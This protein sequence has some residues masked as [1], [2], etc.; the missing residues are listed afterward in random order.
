[1][2]FC[3]AG[4]FPGSPSKEELI[5]LLKIGGAQLLPNLP[6]INSSTNN[7]N[8]RS[9]G[10]SSTKLLVHEQSTDSESATKLL[11]E[12]GLMP[13]SYMWLLDSIS[14]FKLVDESRFRLA[15]DRHLFET[16][17]SMAI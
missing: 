1:M 9:F 14:S 10:Y 3:L 2:T 12:S 15:N 13:L 5:D 17:H 8:R 16:Q 11:N 4:E 6:S 7:N